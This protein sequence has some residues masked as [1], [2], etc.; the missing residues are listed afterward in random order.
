MGIIHIVAPAHLPATQF[1]LGAAYFAPLTRGI[2]TIYETLRKTY[3]VW[4]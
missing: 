1:E 2:W 3:C 4:R